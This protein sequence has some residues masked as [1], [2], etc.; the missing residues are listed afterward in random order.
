MKRTIRRISLKL[1][2][3]KWKMLLEIAKAYAKQKDYFLL[4][5]GLPARFSSYKRYT[6]PRNELVKSDFV[7]PTGLQARMWKLALK[8]AFETIDRNWLA[9]AK[10]LRPRVAFMHKQFSKTGSHYA[11]WVLKK[12]QRMAQLM[13]GKEELPEHFRRVK[14][15]R[16]FLKRTIRTSCGAHPRVRLRRSFALDSGMY[17]IFSHN[18][19]Q[20]ISIMTLVSRQR[21]VIPL[22]GFTVIRGTIR[23]VLDFEK[24][25]VEIHYTVDIKPK[26]AKQPAIGIDLGITEV[27]SDSD[28]NQWGEGFGTTLANYSE[29]LNDKGK[30]RNRLANI[31]K[32]AVDKGN[33]AK[34]RRIDKFNLGRKK[35]KRR[36]GSMRATLA[37]QINESLNQL[38]RA[39]SPQL[40][41]H[42][43]LGQFNRTKSRRFN[44]LVHLWTHG[45]VKS[46]LDFKALVGGSDRKQVNPAYTSQM[47]SH[48]GFVHR[49]NR[50]GDVFHCQFCGQD[51]HSDCLAAMNLLN[52]ADDPEIFQWTPP[53]QVKR[54]LISRFHRRLESWE[55]NFTKEQANLSAL[56]KMKFLATVPGRTPDTNHSH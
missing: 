33:K 18:G 4:T 31:K 56:S 41:V 47:C 37:R 9:L 7:S 27:M 23:V 29:K 28:G 35:Q 19:R 34:A 39:K 12:S 5:Y 36:A 44:R 49:Q 52:R 30:K 45:L 2:K 32:K 46:R 13:S 11:F 51:G 43:K 14:K 25:R 21:L 24:E 10:E 3:V 17:R 8:D 48:C 50:K 53:E 54:I 6:I 40:I 38:Y 16:T 26:K 20:Y 55:F 1:N 15:V 22:T 42:E